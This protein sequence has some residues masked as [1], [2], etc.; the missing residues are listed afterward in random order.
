ML[1]KL[2]RLKFRRRK[3][4]LKL[5]EAEIA[6]IADKIVGKTAGESV[7]DATIKMATEAAYQ[8]GNNTDRIVEVADKIGRG[9]DNV[10]GV[11]A[12]LLGGVNLQEL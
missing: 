7:R 6:K 3:A 9:V 1:K 11:G 2:N 12:A 5:S 8:A 10:L 4:E